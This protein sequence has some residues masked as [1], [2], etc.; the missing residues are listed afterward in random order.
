MN[1][2]HMNIQIKRLFAKVDDSP[3]DELLSLAEIKKHA[4]VFTDMRLLDAVKV[5]HEDI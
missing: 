2:I 5:L 1:R 3:K 4:D